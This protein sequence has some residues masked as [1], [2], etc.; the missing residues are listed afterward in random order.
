[1][2]KIKYLDIHADLVFR[3]DTKSAQKFLD[4]QEKFF[5]PNYVPKSEKRPISGGGASKN[6]SY[7]M[8]EVCIHG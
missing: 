2:T 1:M 6:F 7:S 4:V 8:T 5:D 3:G